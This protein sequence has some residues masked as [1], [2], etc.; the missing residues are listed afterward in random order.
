[1]AADLVDWLLRATLS[2][3]AAIVLVLVLR[4]LWRRALGT[5]S[6]LWPWLLV[7]ALLVAVSVPRPAQVVAMPEAAPSA[8]STERGMRAGRS[9]DADA[10]TV[11]EVTAG[12]PPHG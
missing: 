11:R 5:S 1:M 6:V 10:G 4:P 7:P 8:A 12:R 3:S 2:T 9:D